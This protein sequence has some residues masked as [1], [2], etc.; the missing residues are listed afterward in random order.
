MPSGS[1]TDRFGSAPPSNSTRATSQAS[2]YNCGFPSIRQ[3][4][5]LDIAAF[6]IYRNSDL[7]WKVYSV[8]GLYP[9]S[10]NFCTTDGKQHLTASY[11][12][13][14]S[15]RSNPCFKNSSAIDTQSS[16]SSLRA[17]NRF[18][19]RCCE[20]CPKLF[21]EASSSKSRLRNCSK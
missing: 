12:A 14:G 10:R 2:W 3:Q 17:L 20:L 7:S 5:I 21:C 18:F 8:L 9:V 19:N 6:N 4:L 1:S 15:L 16:G 11:T 13:V